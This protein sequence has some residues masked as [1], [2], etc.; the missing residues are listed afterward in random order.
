MLGNFTP[1]CMGVKVIIEDAN[2][3]KTGVPCQNLLSLLHLLRYHYS[4]FFMYVLNSS[5]S[6]TWSNSNHVTAS[7][8]ITTKPNASNKHL[9]QVCIFLKFNLE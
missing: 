8:S 2:L 6:I 5:L 9:K 4:G 7:D 3:A 1:W